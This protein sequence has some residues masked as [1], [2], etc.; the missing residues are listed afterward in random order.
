MPRFEE[1]YENLRCQITIERTRSCDASPSH[2]TWQNL[3]A[4]SSNGRDLMV[5]IRIHA[6]HLS[7]YLNMKSYI[8]PSR[9]I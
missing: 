2:V 5:K 3:S 8:Q 9:P 6:F 1:S 7:H 4:R